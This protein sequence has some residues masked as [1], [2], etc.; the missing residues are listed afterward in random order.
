LKLPSKMATFQPMLDLASSFVALGV[1]FQ[2]RHYGSFP[3]HLKGSLTRDA[4]DGRSASC[5]RV[6]E[7][8]SAL[9]G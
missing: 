9:K 1:R 3:R 8:P 5:N 2:R 4:I 6:A 7:C